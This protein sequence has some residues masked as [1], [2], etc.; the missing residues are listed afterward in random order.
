MR[1]SRVLVFLTHLGRAAA[2]LLPAFLLLIAALRMLDQGSLNLWL[3]SAFQLLVCLLTFMSRQNPRQ[4]LGPS[5]ITLYVIALGWLW[6]G[7]P[8]GDD[9]FVSLAKALL[10]IVPLLC[11]SLQV[12]VE[13]GAT[14]VRRAR[15]LADRL[16]A[17]REWPAE[18]SACRTLP[19]VKALREAVQINAT[20]ALALLADPRPQVQVAALSALEFRKEWKPGQAEIVLQAAQRAREAAVRAA[21]VAALGNVDERELI[22]ALA[23]FLRDPSW[24]V[25]RAATEAVLWD[26][27]RRWGWVRH[28]LRRALSDPLCAEDGPLRH[29]GQMLTGEAIADLTAWVAQKGLLGQRA[30]LTL[31]LHYARVLSESPS[32]EIIADM[33]R[34]L[35]QP[36]TPAPL[37]LELARLLA[38]AHA[39]DGPLLEGLLESAN[40]APLRLL[41]IE[42]LLTD[43]TAHPGAVTALKDLARLPNREIAL[44]AADVVQR[45]LGVDLGLALAEPLPPHHSRQAAEVTRRLMQWALL[46]EASERARRVAE[47]VA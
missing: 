11:F 41:A 43:G 30:A 22:E 31:G 4:P 21:A 7:T 38:K 6:L 28:S 25:R 13:T 16:A 8:G 14:A 26:S 12:L 10:L 46:P 34:Q 2:L 33:R 23:E 18:L 40:P 37:R 32:E 24:E 27:E 44:T 39:L 36:H 19:E 15:L 45:R 17:R 42:S 5:V 9:W 1:S 3:G 35:E 29:E 47:P 20:P